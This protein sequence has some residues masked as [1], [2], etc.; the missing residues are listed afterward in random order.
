MSGFA[1]IG[2]E[3]VYMSSLGCFIDAFELIRRQV[4]VLFHTRE[5]VAMQTQVY[6]LTPDGRPVRMAD[7]RTLSADG[8]LDKQSQYDL[9]HLPGFV[10]GD[11]PSLD[12]KLAIAGPLCSWLQHQ[13]TG[14][15]VISASGSA[16]FLLAEAGLLDSG[17]T[18]LTRPLIP[19]FRKRYPKV[20]V[21]PQVPVVEH[22]RILTGSGLAADTM[23]L[24]QVVERVTAPQI[25]RW[26]G[27]VTGLHQASEDQLAEDP[28]VANAQLWLEERFAQNVR[29]SDLAKALAISQQTLLRHFQRHLNTTPRDYVRRLRVESAQQLLLRTSRSIDQIAALVGYD[30]VHSF[31]EVFRELTGFSPSRYRA[32]HKKPGDL[33]HDED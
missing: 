13:H 26:L 27:D 22:G 2:L 5:R 23:L 11:E 4:P 28:V 19:L 25:A 29:I 24:A 8:Q 21:S 33:L 18:A 12:A 6:F 30:D 1:A 31:R 16:V 14:G 3:G 17:M 32:A 10:V 9:V 7:G 15:A 20:Q